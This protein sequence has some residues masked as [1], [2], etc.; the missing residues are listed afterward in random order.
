M[1]AYSVVLITIG[2]YIVNL[3]FGERYYESIYYYPFICPYVI[4]VT[5]LVIVMNYTLAYGKMTFFTGSMLVGFIGIF[6]GVQIINVPITI[7]FIFL[8]VIINMLLILNIVNIF[9]NLQKESKNSP[10]EQ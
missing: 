9:R 2:K 1:V 4:G 10:E 3:L 6:A 8:S 7:L 5:G